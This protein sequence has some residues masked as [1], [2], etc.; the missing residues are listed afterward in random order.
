V[1]VLLLIGRRLESPQ[2]MADLLLPP[3]DVLHHARKAGLLLDG[4][5]DNEDEDED[6][7]SVSADKSSRKGS[8][9]DAGTTR[10]AEDAASLLSTP[11]GEALLRSASGPF[12]MGRGKPAYHFAP[13]TPLCLH[14][15]HFNGLRFWCPASSLAES[16]LV[17]EGVW[18]RRTVAAQLAAQGLRTVYDQPLAAPP[19]APF[20]D[21]HR[22]G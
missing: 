11:G 21:A 22:L 1:A 7:P 18:S 14:H 15:C 9:M 13:E 12:G 17:F 8:T 16:A 20:A 6:K 4:D 2:A 10:P 19:A 3:A 5:N